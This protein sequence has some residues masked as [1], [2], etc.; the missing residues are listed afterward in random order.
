MKPASMK[1]RLKIDAVGKD[2]NEI[3]KCLVKVFEAIQQGEVC[4]EV[5]FKDS[6]VTFT[7]ETQNP[8]DY[9]MP[10]D[11]INFKD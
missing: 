2:L 7:F 8:E 3:R 9:M 10:E 6:C 11:E 4:N 1:H 5:Y